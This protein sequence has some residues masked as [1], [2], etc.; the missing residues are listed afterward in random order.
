MDYMYKLTNGIFSFFNEVLEFSYGFQAQTA[1]VFHVI[2]GMELINRFQ[3]YFFTFTVFIDEVML[4][5][6]SSLD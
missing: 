2:K 1:F 6:L 3:S 4:S 5:F